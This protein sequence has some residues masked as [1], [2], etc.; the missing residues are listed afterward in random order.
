MYGIILFIYRQTTG[1]YIEIPYFTINAGDMG[2]LEYKYNQRGNISKLIST[3]N[4]GNIFGVCM[5]MLFPTFYS[6]EKS[7]I[8]ISIVI[9]A[10]ILTLSRTVWIGLA[11]F[12]II[13]NRKRLAEL[14]KIYLYVG[15]I[16][17]LFST[18]IL[19]KY[20]QYASLYDFIFDGN[21]GGRLTQVRNF[22]GLTLFGSEVYKEVNEIVYLSILKQLGVIGLLLY[23]FSFFMPIY[24]YFN[25][26]DNRKE[27]VYG[28]II[29][30]IVSMSD[31]AVL[32]IPT[33]V[34]FYF[35]CTMAFIPKK[36]S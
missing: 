18:I 36:T 10:L 33:L 7:K 26:K 3:Y 20:F 5:L 6:L 9:I 11:I 30:L 27:Y 32:Y 17:F 15:I 22:E 14:V 31:G 19:S 34:F 28:A 12:F 1:D 2:E 25:T 23:C 29:Y 35:I 8:K 16:M 4:N 24:M 13:K 21:L